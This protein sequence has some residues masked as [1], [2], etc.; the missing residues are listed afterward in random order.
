MTGL[1]KLDTRRRVTRDAILPGVH[2]VLHDVPTGRFRRNVLIMFRPETSLRQEKSVNEAPI[3]PCREM[4]A[5]LL[6]RAALLRHADGAAL[7]FRPTHRSMAGST[8]RQR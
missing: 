5:Q 3:Q 7:M 1:P 8:Q 4:L 2:A 6:S